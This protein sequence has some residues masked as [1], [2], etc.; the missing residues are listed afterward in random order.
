MTAKGNVYPDAEGPRKG[1][2]RRWGL[3]NLL[4]TLAEEISERGGF[5]A[6]RGRSVHAAE[7]VRCPWCQGDVY[8]V[9]RRMIDRF[10]S[11]LSPRQRYRCMSWSCRWEGTL[12]VKR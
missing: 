10:A 9:R 2:G 12:R 5:G 8:R 6:S 1:G 4:N 7:D 11:V 3:G